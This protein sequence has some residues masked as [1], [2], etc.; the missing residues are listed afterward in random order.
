MRFKERINNNRFK[1]MDFHL[2]Y[3]SL[4]AHFI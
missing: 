1:D 3:S 2:G 4:E